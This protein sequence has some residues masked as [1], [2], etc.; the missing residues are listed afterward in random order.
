MEHFEFEVEDIHADNNS[1]YSSNFK[2]PGFPEP[3]SGDP[4]SPEPNLNEPKSI[5]RPS[6]IVYPPLDILRHA[7]NC[8]SPQNNCN[9]FYCEILKK[10]AKKAI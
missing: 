10:I 5:N 9:I 3:C 8:F 6:F 1:T 7:Y 4:K 2:N